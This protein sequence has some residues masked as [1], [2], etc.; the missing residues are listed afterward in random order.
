M[1]YLKLKNIL[2]FILVMVTFAVG[3]FIVSTFIFVERPTPV[4]VIY[5]YERI[6]FWPDVD[7]ITA[8]VSPRGC[9]STTCTSPRLQ[10]GTAIVDVHEYQIQLETRFVLVEGTRF[11]LPC[12]ENCAGGGTVQF[13]LGHLIPNKYEVWFRDEKVGD[14]DIFSGLPTPRQC[15]LFMEQ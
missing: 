12:T 9:Y 6:C 13:N 1:K 4:G 14:L 11:P 10:A 8:A 15:F 5:D 2:T 7:G 3:H